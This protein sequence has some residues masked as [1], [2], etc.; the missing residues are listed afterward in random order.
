MFDMY[1]SYPIVTGKGQTEI[2]GTEI[3]IKERITRKEEYIYLYVHYL[4]DSIGE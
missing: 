3:K 4:V 2:K 1:A